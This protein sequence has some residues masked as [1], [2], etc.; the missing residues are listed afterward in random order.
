MLKLGEACRGITFGEAGQHDQ[1]FFSAITANEVVRTNVLSHPASGVAQDQVASE[2]TE[3]VIDFLE[4]VDVGQDD[5]KR[6]AFSEGPVY[7]PLKDVEDRGTVP[8]VS[9]RIMSRLLVQG[10]AGGQQLHLFGLELAGTLRDELFQQLLPLD[11]PAL[12]PAP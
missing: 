11:E 3:G 1:E 4:V 2:V 12:T 10:F 8:Q 7:L 6:C 9:Q 5:G